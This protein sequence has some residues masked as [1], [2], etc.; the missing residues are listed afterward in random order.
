MN[1]VND[2]IVGDFCSL[3]Q[4]AIFPFF[5]L[6]IRRVKD[7]KNHYIFHKIEKCSLLILNQATKIICITTQF[8]KTIKKIDFQK[9]ILQLFNIKYF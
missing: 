9:I 8:G 7:F 3:P 1:L 2:R 6:I 4:R 5:F